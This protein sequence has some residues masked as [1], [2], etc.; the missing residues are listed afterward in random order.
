MGGAGLIAG[1][2]MAF[3]TLKP[4][5]EVVGVEPVNVQSFTEAIKAGQPVD[6]FRAG[7]LADGL[8]V[9]FVGPNAFEIA[10]H[11]VDKTVLVDERMIAISVLRLV[12]K[13]DWN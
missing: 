7:T 1:M 9:P 11:Y 10:R 8:A 4:D 6:G 3:K 2:A 5:V 12:G 13:L